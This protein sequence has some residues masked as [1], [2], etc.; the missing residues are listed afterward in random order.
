MDASAE[1]FTGIAG[2]RPGWDLPPLHPGLQQTPSDCL[3]ALTERSKCPQWCAAT[4]RKH[5]IFY[6]L[7]YIDF[8][9]FQHEN[10]IIV[11]YGPISD[12]I[13]LAKI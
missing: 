2:R 8:H 12:V 11:Y 7:D 6:L 13:F 5:F 10:C 1:G 9:F 3:E 4:E